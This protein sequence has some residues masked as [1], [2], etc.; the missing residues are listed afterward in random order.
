[1][2]SIPLDMDDIFGEDEAVEDFN[3]SRLPDLEDELEPMRAVRNEENDDDEN[4][5]EDTGNFI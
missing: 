4:V 3:P 2:E 1:M 5:Q